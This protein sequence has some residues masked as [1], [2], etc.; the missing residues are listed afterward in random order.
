MDIIEELNISLH[1]YIN[2]TIYDEE[3]GVYFIKQL[4]AQVRHMKIEIYS[5]D[6]NPPHFHVSSK[7]GSINATFRLDNCDL[8]NG[9]LRKGDRKK[10]EAFFS[11]SKNNDLMKNLWNTSKDERRRIE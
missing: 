6:H 1:K 8:I 7:D 2:K 10:I 9:S 11:N 5:N 4:V 3:V